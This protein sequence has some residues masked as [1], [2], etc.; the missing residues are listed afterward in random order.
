[1]PALS[2]WCIRAA[3]CYLIAGMALGAW[4]LIL[5][6]RR[7]YGLSHPWP[8]LHGHLLLVGFLLLLIFG[9]AFWMFPKV[10]GS[11][12]PA[13]WGWIG[14]A[15]L[16]AGLIGRVVA[17]PLADSG[18]GPAGWRVALSVAAVLPVAGAIAFA[19]ALWPRVRA[20]MSRQEAERMRQERASTPAA[21]RARA[22]GPGGD[23]RGT[24]PPG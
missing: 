17:E 15:L 8:T 23:D 12:G 21:E 16:N 14:F 24:T 10:R 5:Q 18:G 13:R 11:R 7:G 1:M 22:R 20:A 4:I 3:F 19:V 6:A 9:V 2:R